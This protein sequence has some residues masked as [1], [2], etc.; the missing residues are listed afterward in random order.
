MSKWFSKRG[1]T[2]SLN[3]LFPI[4][5]ATFVHNIPQVVTLQREIFF[6]FNSAL[7]SS[8]CWALWMVVM[9]TFQEPIGLVKEFVYSRFEVLLPC[10]TNSKGV[11][12]MVAISLSWKSVLALTCQILE[13]NFLMAVSKAVSGFWKQ[14]V[15]LLWVFIRKFK[16]M[17]KLWLVAPENL[18]LWLVV[19]WCSGY[20]CCTT[21]FN[22]AWT[23]VLHRFKS[24]LQRVGNLRWWGSKW[25][26]LVNHTTKKKIFFL[27]SICFPHLTNHQFVKLSHRRVVYVSISP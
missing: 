14:W 3:G 12:S 19:L 1:R 24:Y 20:C 2:P 17:I 18:K 16:T 4:T 8:F 13:L 6:F 23:Q 27:S 25:L 7:T 26:L 5:S 10:N 22:Q 21:S 9:R 11:W 15:F